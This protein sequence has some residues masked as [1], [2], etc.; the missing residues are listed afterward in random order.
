MTFSRTYRKKSRHKHTSV[1]KKF[2]PHRP[3]KIEKKIYF[4]G[5]HDRRAYS[6]SASSHVSFPSSELTKSQTC[7]QKRNVTNDKCKQDQNEA[8]KDEF[9]KLVT[10]SSFMKEK[11]GQNSNVTKKCVKLP[12][13][14]KV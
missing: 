4:A 10:F 13:L 7:K 9:T 3:S 12:D 14:L 8:T 5:H 2:V 6:T 1:N 11:T